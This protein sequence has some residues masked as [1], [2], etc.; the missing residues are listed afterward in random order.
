MP[1]SIPAIDRFNSLKTKQQLLSQ[2]LA[3]LNGRLES[4]RDRYQDI[5][6]ELGTFGIG[7]LDELANAIT[8]VNKQIEDDLATAEATIAQMEAE[9]R[10]IDS[11]E[12]GTPERG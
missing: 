6:R 8:A 5:M 9:L 10:A 12:V 7:S 2:Q 11:Q 1:V 4:S 3:T